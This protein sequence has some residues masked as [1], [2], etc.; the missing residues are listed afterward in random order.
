MNRGLENFET[1]CPRK[2]RQHHDAGARAKPQPPFECG[3]PGPL[4]QCIKV[5]KHR[6][7]RRSTVNV[8]AA[9][10]HRYVRAVTC[11]LDS[12]DS[13]VWF[14]DV[15]ARLSSRLDRLTLC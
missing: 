3:S 7:I 4:V 12:V 10:H 2:P 5:G 9:A 8:T 6:F 11:K 15:L 13:P 14:V 1:C